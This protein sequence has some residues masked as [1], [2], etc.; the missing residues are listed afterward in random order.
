MN[1]PNDDGQSP[2]HLAAR[3]SNVKMVKRL[4]V[5][6][7]FAKIPESKEGNNILHIAVIENCEE[8]V[9]YILAGTRLDSM[10]TNNSD[11]SPLDLA[12]TIES[13]N[14]K[15][16]EMLEEVDTS[17]ASKKKVNLLITLEKCLFLFIFFSYI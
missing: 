5:N 13:T 12:L 4:V 14:P 3:K 1:L 9:K 6:G 17:A 15:I 7:A 10:Q 11:K 16:I 8:L 2:L